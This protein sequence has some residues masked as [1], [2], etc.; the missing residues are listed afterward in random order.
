L[1]N[2][3]KRN[4]L[5]KLL[6]IN[7]WIHD[8]A[9]FDLWLKPLGLLYIA[10]FL[11]KKGFRT[12]FLDCLDRFHPSLI[13]NGI[14]T[15]NRK[16]GRGKFYSQKIAK[17]S[18]LKSVPRHFK[19]FGIPY[20][21]VRRELAQKRDTDVVL[22]TSVMTYWYSG[23]F[24]MI[25]LVREEIPGAKII[26]GGIYP[27]L[28][29]R[30]A[31]E[32]SGADVVISGFDVDGLLSEL[33][34]RGEEGFSP[35]KFYNEISPDYGLY[36]KLPYVSM[37]TSAGCPFHCSYCVSDIMWG[38]FFA[39][40]KD[41]LVSDIE[42][43][44]KKLNVK[45]I[46]FYDDA[47]LYRSNEH[48]LPLFE[49]IYK[50]GYRVQFHTPNGLNARFINEDVAEM[51]FRCNFRTIR[52]GFESANEDFQ[53]KTGNKVTKDEL[54]G[55][56]SNLEKAGIS[57]KDIGIYIMAGRTDEGMKDVFGTL[58]FIAGLGTKVFV[59]EYSPV[60]GSRDFERY[61]NFKELDPL[62]QSNSIAFLKNGW[63]FTKM[64]KVKDLKDL[65]NYA[66]NKNIDISPLI[67]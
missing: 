39:F 56:I 23:V 55:S 30:H 62:W 12:E 34:D 21:L 38:E 18:V 64:Q 57:K 32:K 6:L 14:S 49:E 33:G 40:S 43:Y 65:I 10:S 36:E 5:K 61:P 52:I 8:F 2:P 41:K 50:M 37:L 25:Q 51:L 17:P 46:A 20:S 44:V 27:T 26:L 29:T 16:F 59:S 54:S 58:K 31:R 9:A 60:P 45:D 11:R 63:D 19:R 7:P 15:A 53:K 22:I 4:K 48:F 1:R 66:V 3:G 35:E 24:E 67:K 28:L 42:R 47:L 13:S